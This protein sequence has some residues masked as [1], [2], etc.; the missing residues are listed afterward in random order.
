MF[1]IA[2]TTMRKH[3]GTSR[4]CKNT[5]FVAKA[6]LWAMCEYNRMHECVTLLNILQIA[7]IAT[8]S[9]LSSFSVDQW[10][11]GDLANCNTFDYIVNIS[12]YTS[13]DSVAGHTM[14]YSMTAA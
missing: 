7:N 11:L 9:H 5:T 8:K 14:S 4:I 10:R 2:Q 12:Y 3:V 13:M 1:S 6:Q